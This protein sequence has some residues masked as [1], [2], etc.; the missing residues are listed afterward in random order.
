MNA[1]QGQHVLVVE[2]QVIH[3]GYMFDGKPQL[4]L[5]FYLGQFSCSLIF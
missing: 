2:L 3:I 5:Y 4:C 1:F